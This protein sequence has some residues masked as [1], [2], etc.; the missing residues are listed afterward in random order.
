MKDH[1]DLL[2]LKQYLN[3]EKNHINELKYV[4]TKTLI[5][6]ASLSILFLKNSLSI[7]ESRAEYFR[8]ENIKITAWSPFF[9]ILQIT[10][11]LIH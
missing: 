10:I 2:E 8:I 6:D 11:I 4:F 1:L 5:E 9:L 3:L 7:H